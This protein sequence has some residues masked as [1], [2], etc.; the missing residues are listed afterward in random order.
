ML[1]GLQVGLGWG[2]PENSPATGNLLDGWLVK[3]REMRK[4]LCVLSQWRGPREWGVQLSG[5]VTADLPLGSP[6]YWSRL[7]FGAPQACR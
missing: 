3:F 5:S 2:G 7:C 6:Q 1:A 4:D